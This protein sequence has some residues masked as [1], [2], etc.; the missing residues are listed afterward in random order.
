[1]CSLQQASSNGDGYSQELL[2]KLLLPIGF[3]LVSA[4]LS[5]QLLFKVGDAY[6]QHT[7]WHLRTPQGY[8]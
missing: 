7:D 1:M 6:Q 3:Q 2:I 4:H 8:Q 5:E